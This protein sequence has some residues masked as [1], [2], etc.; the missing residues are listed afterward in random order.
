MAKFIIF[1]TWLQGGYVYAH[2]SAWGHSL[3]SMHFILSLCEQK[4]CMLNWPLH[5]IN[6]MKKPESVKGKKY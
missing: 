2:T 6:D 5:Y 3:Y 1:I 4:Y